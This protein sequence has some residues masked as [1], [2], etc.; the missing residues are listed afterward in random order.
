M[1]LGISQL[2]FNYLLLS[3]PLNKRIHV[4]QKHKMCITSPLA[5]STCQRAG[6][7]L[8]FSARDHFYCQ[9]LLEKFLL[10]RVN[11]T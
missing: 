2:F 3:K 4:V 9:V 11:F 5:I 10:H 6:T 8:L 1:S 7:S